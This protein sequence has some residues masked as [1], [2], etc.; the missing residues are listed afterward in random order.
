M[1]SYVI[2]FYSTNRNAKN[3]VVLNNGSG[4]HNVSIYVVERG[5]TQREVIPTLGRSTL[6]DQGSGVMI[7]SLIRS[8]IMTLDVNYQVLPIALPT[9]HLNLNA[10]GGQLHT[11]SQ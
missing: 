3:K 9:M 7:L 8:L 4:Y 11:L 2:Y 10:S 6:C 1:C 5:D